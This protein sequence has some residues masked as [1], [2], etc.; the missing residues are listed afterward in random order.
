MRNS[1]AEFQNYLIKI[2]SFFALVQGFFL[3]CDIS[4]TLP[5]TH[6]YIIISVTDSV[7][8]YEKSDCN[9]NAYET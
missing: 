3:I 2:F 5:L 9:K 7:F 6:R 4:V 8:I 1:T